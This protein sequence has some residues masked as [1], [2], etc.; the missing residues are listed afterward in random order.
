MWE[1]KKQKAAQPDSE[2]FTVLGKDVTFQGI[3]H[4]EGTVQLDG[5]FEGEIHTKGVLMAG[6]HAVI[7][8]LV[9]V[10]TLISSGTIHGAITASEK[11]RLLKT[12]VQIGDVQAPSLSIEEGAYF[13]GRIDMGP[14]P[15]VEGSAE[16]I[17]ALPERA[18]SEMNGTVPLTEAAAARTQLDYDQV[19][20]ELIHRSVTR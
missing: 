4:F 17:I 13:K 19:Q 14:R 11:V 9:S 6:E 10:G 5:R 20:D 3:V 1:S 7:R 18:A 2:H 8:G 16:T 15:S 12:A